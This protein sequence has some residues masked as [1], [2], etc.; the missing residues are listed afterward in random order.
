MI[1]P[2]Y[3]HKLIAQGENQTLDFKFE[4]ADSR[5]IARTF[6]AFANTKGGKL[7]IGV[8]DNG[9]IAG[10]RTDEEKFMAEKAIHHYCK[11]LIE[12]RSK[13]WIVEGKKVLEITIKPGKEKPYFALDTNGKWLAYVRVNDQNVLAGKVIVNAWI[14]KGKP[15]GTYINYGENEKLLLEY[16]EKKQSITLF[17]FVQFAGVTE[18]KAEVILTNFLALDI[19]KAI[20]SE[21]EV[22]YCLSNNEGEIV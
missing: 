20:V 14:R 4:I 17:D 21:K 16:L 19:I 2:H 8:K 22:L 15:E 11:P 13:E 7:L 12:S 10:I 3:I 6:S 9:T 18:H 1:K 5:K